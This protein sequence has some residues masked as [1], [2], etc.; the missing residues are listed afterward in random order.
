MIEVAPN[1]HVSNQ[2]SCFYEEREGWAVI[3]ACVSPCYEQAV[4]DPDHDPPE[5]EELIALERGNHLYL[6]M[7][8][9]ERPRV[10]PFLYAASK[11]FLAKHLQNGKVVIHCNDG[12]SRAPAV[13]LIY[14][15]WSGGLPSDN[16]DSAYNA[17]RLVYPD[18]SPGAGIFANMNMRWADLIAT[19]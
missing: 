15:A 9:G 4:N 2:E 13:A 6:N 19:D 3:H 17:F 8:D 18:F 16:Y 12:D 14:L 5:A 1:L 11:A 10:P 7:V